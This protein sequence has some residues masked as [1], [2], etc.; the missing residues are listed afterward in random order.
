MSVTSAT[1]RPC[2]TQ[3]RTSRTRPLVQTHRLI[4]SLACA[5]AFASSRC[6]GAGPTQA[7]DDS[8]VASDVTTVDSG[9]ATSLTE[10]STHDAGGA[11][12]SVTLLGCPQA[13]YAGTFS[14]G[15]S[16]FQ[17]VM[18]TG[19]AELGVASSTCTTCDVS[20]TYTPGTTATDEHATLSVSYVS[21]TGWSGEIIADDFGVP[22]TSTSAQTRL[23]AIESQ[24]GGFFTNE[25]CGFGAVPFAYQGIAG[26]GPDSLAKAGTDEPMGALASHGVA[27][28]FA[29][30]LCG[31]GGQLWLGGVDTSV[32]TGLVQYTPLLN[33]DNY[34]AVGV[35]DLLVGGTSLGLTSTNIGD[36]VVDTDTTE[37]ELPTSVYQKVR[38]AIAGTAYFQAHFGSSAWFDSGYCTPP[39]D[40]SPPTLAK[41]DSGLPTLTFAIDD[42]M[43]GSFDIALGATDS[44]LEP[45]RKNGVLYYCPEIEASSGGAV[46]G[47]GAMRALLVVMDRAGSRVGF[48]PHGACPA[49]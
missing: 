3:E 36:V 44:Y 41:I 2:L 5:M 21:G 17:L 19:S 11:P 40:A 23:V 42:G 32:A 14:I 12:T 25:G 10:A 8:G 18:D 27:D 22:G 26:F 6:G 24:T 34:Y 47:S 16:P 45:I 35:T 46:L 30:A 39:L 31:S 7:H 4:A 48:A 1:S 38:A 9:D 37:L 15:G 13:G 33:S 29:F 49:P 43:G 28:V 20:P